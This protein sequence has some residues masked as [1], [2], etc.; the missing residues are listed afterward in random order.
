MD[1]AQIERL[2]EELASIKRDAWR[3]EEYLALC[4]KPTG[5]GENA[6]I[7][8]PHNEYAAIVIVEQAG[9]AFHI[10]PAI[11]VEG[12]PHDDVIEHSNG[13][14]YEA[15]FGI[16]AIVTGQDILALKLGYIELRSD[17]VCEADWN[18]MWK[19]YG[20]DGLC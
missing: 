15:L 14:T 9:D 5:E 7:V 10:V 13:F 18:E 1:D 11:I 6:L 2:F 4:V 17:V 16:S 19:M 3:L 12:Y 20:Y 8:C